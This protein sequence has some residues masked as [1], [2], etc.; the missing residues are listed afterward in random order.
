MGSILHEGDHVYFHKNRG[1]PFSQKFDRYE[2]E[3]S[4]FAQK[5]AFLRKAANYER[6]RGNESAA[7]KLENLA[8]Q[9][10]ARLARGFG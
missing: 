3:A 5:A 1:A 2:I 9:V 7:Q 8:S 6:G 4:A 10:D